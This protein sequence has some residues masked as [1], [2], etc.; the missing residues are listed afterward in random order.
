MPTNPT[1]SVNRMWSFLLTEVFKPKSDNP[2]KVVS[3]S[4]HQG[5]IRGIDTAE[6]SDRVEID[7]VPNLPRS[8]VWGPG[9][10]AAVE[11]PLTE[12]GRFTIEVGSGDSQHGFIRE[13]IG[14]A[15]SWA[16]DETFWNQIFVE[17]VD[18]DSLP[19]LLYTEGDLMVF[20]L[21]RALYPT[22]LAVAENLSSGDAGLRGRVL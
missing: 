4:I 10:T 18:A 13:T 9:G 1:N 20:T 21:E 22:N 12:V 6:I 14:N 16:F 8:Y 17:G 3:R 7:I 2:N 11:T 5:I 15:I 19:F